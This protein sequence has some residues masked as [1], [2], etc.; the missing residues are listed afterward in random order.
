[1]YKQNKH[2]I[3]LLSRKGQIAT[4]HSKRTMKV[5]KKF[6]ELGIIEKESTFQ[7]RVGVN[8][9]N[10]QV[11]KDKRQTGELPE[12]NAGLP[13]GTWAEFPYVIEHKNEYYVRCT[14]LRNN[15]V[16]T[17]LYW[18]NGMQIT[19]EEAQEACLASEFKEDRTNDVFNIKVASIL[20]VK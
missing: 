8:Y 2:V 17:T 5:R 3:T 14:L 15:F 9:D 13:W 1:M 18:R 20:D 19:A 4:I 7:V 10:I 16:P 6:E 12:E 11:V